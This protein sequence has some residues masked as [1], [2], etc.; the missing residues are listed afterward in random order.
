MSFREAD[1]NRDY[2][3]SRSPE[4]RM[5]AAWYL[6]AT[7]WGFDPHNPPPMDKTVFSCKKRP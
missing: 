7:A 5:A 2:W 3:M 4:E 6:I 1:N